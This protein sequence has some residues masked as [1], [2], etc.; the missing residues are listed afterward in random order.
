M[1]VSGNIGN[2]GG[3]QHGFGGNTPNMQT[4]STELVFLN[5]RD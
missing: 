5:Q 4:G 1:T 3:V 2:F